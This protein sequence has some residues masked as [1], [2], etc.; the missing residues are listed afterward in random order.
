MNFF[1]CGGFTVIDG[2][3][4]PGIDKGVTAAL[5][6]S[7][8]AVVLC[9]SDKDYEQSAEEAIKRL[10]DKKAG[11]KAVVPGGPQNVTEKLAH[12]GADDFINS[13]SDVLEVLERYQQTLL[14]GEVG[15]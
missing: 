6:E 4:S 10:K 2:A 15:P 3:E 12:A 11:I 5:R 9:G 13:D 8:L 1:G 14:S 7:P